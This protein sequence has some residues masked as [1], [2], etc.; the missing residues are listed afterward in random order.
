LVGSE[1]GGRIIGLLWFTL[2]CAVADDSLGERL[3]DAVTQGDVTQTRELLDPW[4]RTS[5]PFPRG[6]AP[7]V[8]RGSERPLAEMDLS[9]KEP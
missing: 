5:K 1:N 3:V 2:I 9:E 6:L 7:E 4:H 8:A